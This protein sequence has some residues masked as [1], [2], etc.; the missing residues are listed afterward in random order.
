MKL[1]PVIANGNSIVNR[2]GY[3]HMMAIVQGDGGGPQV[4]LKDP[5]VAYTLRQHVSFFAALT[6]VAPQITE[7]RRRD[8][9]ETLLQ[10]LHED[11][12]PSKLGALLA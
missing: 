10:K 12:V 3:G 2:L 8:Y 1:S 9:I 4:E 6:M 11:Q 5:C 7:D